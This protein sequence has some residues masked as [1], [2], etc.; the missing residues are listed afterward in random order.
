MADVLTAIGTILQNAGVGTMATDIWGAEMP[1]TPDAS[2]A[3]LEATGFGP[4]FTMGAAGAAISRPRVRVL[5]RAARGDYSAAKTKI[6]ACVAAL[7]VI[8]ASTVAGVTFLTILQE[9]DP[10]PVRFDDD[11]RPVMECDF[12]CWI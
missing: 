7:G 6:D 10:Y 8:R 1:D 2:V 5:A 4:M 9:T 11:D 3:V 12:T